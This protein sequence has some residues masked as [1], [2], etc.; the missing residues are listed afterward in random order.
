[1]SPANSEN[2]E[3]DSSS[4]E[5]SELLS[6]LATGTPVVPSIET[7]QV[8]KSE[9]SEAHSSIL[10]P[11]PSSATKMAEPGGDFSH[12]IGPDA[13][14]ILTQLLSRFERMETRV[15]ELATNRTLS[16]SP[17][18]GARPAGRD[19]SVAHSAFGGTNF[20]PY[21]F[22]AWDA[23]KPYGTDQNAKN[24]DYNDKRRKQGIDPSEFAG[25]K[26][27][28]DAWVTKLADKFV[29]DDETFKTERSRM[30][31]VNSLLSGVPATL[32]QGRYRSTTYPFSNAAEMISTIQAV[33][34]DEN[35]A[36][37]A[38][39]EL[40][41]MLFDPNDKEMDIYQFIA[42][43]NGLAD[44]ANVRPEERKSVLY[45]HIP[46]KLN[47]QLLTEAKNPNCSYEAFSALVADSAMAQQRANDQYRAIRE[48]GRAKGRRYIAS[49]KRTTSPSK[50]KRQRSAER[51]SVPSSQM[52]QLS[53]DDRAKLAKENRCFVCQ[54][55]GHRARECPD[56]KAIA[57]LMAEESDTDE[58]VAETSE[59]E[60]SEN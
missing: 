12:T 3:D 14:A 36:S 21:G 59:K 57:A 48:K 32:V 42:Q 34:H 53:K 22:A 51:Q 20:V 31:V 46:A 9:H 8:L 35:Q 16:A 30:A 11:L 56:G 58:S 25:D 37:K 38:R 18:S 2:H 23:F 41:K 5:V 1:V 29:E 6:A 54:R 13:T 40:S 50:D 28:F 60:Q 4:L 7:N 52:A 24:P 17:P 19:V 27:Q 55:V 26:S 45:E 39:D 15:A 49:G 47:P 44:T 43:I 10:E 33:Y